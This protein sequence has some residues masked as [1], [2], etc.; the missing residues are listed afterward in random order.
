M[1]SGRL[2]KTTSQK[3]ILSGVKHF[4]QFMQQNCLLLIGGVPTSNPAESG[5]QLCKM[6]CRNADLNLVSRH[7]K[8]LASSHSSCS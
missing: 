8:E 5:S 7:Q 4:H 2:G 6:G 1:L 3:L